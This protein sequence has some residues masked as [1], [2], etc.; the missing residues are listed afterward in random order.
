M[1]GV[2]E[3]SISRFFSPQTIISGVD[4]LNSVVEEIKK[5]GGSKIL[6]VTDPGISEAGLAAPLLDLIKGANIAVDLFDDVNPDPELAKVEACV[7]LLKEGDHDLVVGFGGGSPMDVAKYSA[8]FA[9]HSGSVRDYLGMHLLQRRGLPTIMIPTTAGT[10]AEVTWGAV[11]HDEIDH[12]KKAVW[13]PYVLADTVIVD[14][15]LTVSMPL[16]LT[17]DTGLDTLVHGLEAYVTKEAFH[18]SDALALESISRVG[19]GIRTVVEEGGNLEARYNMSV[20]ATLAGL[21]ICNAGMGAIHA[22]ALLL[23][24]EYGFTH[25][26]SLIVLAPSI[27]EFNL[28]ANYEKY[29]QIAKALGEPTEGLGVEEAARK[30]VG[31]VI[32]IASDLGVS[33]KLRDYDIRKEKLEEMGKRAFEIGQRLLHMN[34]RPLTEEDSVRI[35][36]NA[37]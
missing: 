25:G 4:A 1:R 14:P 17:I 13:S 19:K 15:S 12:V 36:Q 21:T 2:T 22:L 26:K 32:K 33:V 20:A 24:G 16:T 11:F 28:S 8:A 3:N 23:D 34:R 5:L 29:A 9:A 6:V 30:A 31:A 35:Y 7:S 10:G 27:M 18:L 37:Y